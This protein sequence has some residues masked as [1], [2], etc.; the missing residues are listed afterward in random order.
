MEY[1]SERHQPASGG[2]RWGARRTAGQGRPRILTIKRRRHTTAAP[3]RARERPNRQTVTEGASSQ[4]SYSQAT[5]AI[6]R[7]AM[8]SSL[9]LA[10][11]I[12][13]DQMRQKSQ[14]RSDQWFGDYLSLRPLNCDFLRTE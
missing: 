13:V 7:G 6:G 10:V 12:R 4:C 9:H 14:R 11:A 2:A 8:L 5:G 1:R 3:D